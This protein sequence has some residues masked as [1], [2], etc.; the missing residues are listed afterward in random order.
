M[1]VSHVCSTDLVVHNVVVDVLICRLFSRVRLL[2]CY[3]EQI[4]FVNVHF[5]YNCNS[6]LASKEEL[7]DSGSTL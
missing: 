7:S 6:M 5:P 2:N 4:R 3:S 1:S